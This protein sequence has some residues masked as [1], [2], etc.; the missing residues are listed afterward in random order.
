SNQAFAT[1]IGPL[2]EVPILIIL[3]NVALKF[4]AKYF[5]SQRKVLN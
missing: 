5:S 4:R 1:V 2:L 3:V